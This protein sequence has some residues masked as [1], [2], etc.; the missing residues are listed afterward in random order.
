MVVVEEI[1]MHDVLSYK[2][3]NFLLYVVKKRNFK[4]IIS[5]ILLQKL[6]TIF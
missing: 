1:G 6:K 3:N 2:P 5:I 4:T